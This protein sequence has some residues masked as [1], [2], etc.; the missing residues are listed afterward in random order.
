MTK[1]QILELEK[2]YKKFRLKRRVKRAL[3]L[4]VCAGFFV[5]CFV[6]FEIYQNKQDE[7]IVLQ[8]SKNEL[9]KRLEAAKTK[10]LKAQALHEKELLKKDE[11]I[12]A[13]EEELAQKERVK[14]QIS[15]QVLSTKSLE[16]SFLKDED[17]ETAL[18]L[19]S[20]YFSKKD[21]ANALKWSLR[22][23]DLDSSR[24]QTW[25]IYAKSLEKLGRRDE[26]KRVLRLYKEYY[27]TNVVE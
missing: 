26:A 17:I 12:A 2:N 10:A 7:K 4:L 23:N 3:T 15:S 8:K 9:L 13:I 1:T 11:K 24:A 27:G 21:Y 18:K 14:I 20:L 16:K 19:A 6:I 25:Q 5:L 22:A